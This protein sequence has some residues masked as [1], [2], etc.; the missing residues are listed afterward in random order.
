MT[1]NSVASARKLTA[2][3]STPANKYLGLTISGGEGALTINVAPEDFAREINAAGIPGLTVTYEK[4]V[5][6][7]T[8]PGAYHDKD[9]DLWVRDRDGNWIDFSLGV[10]LDRRPGTNPPKQY[11]PYTRLIPET[12]ADL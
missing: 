4:P 11:G 12:E 2:E 1:I 6:M 3:A 7:P 9:G 10:R 8:E 5:E